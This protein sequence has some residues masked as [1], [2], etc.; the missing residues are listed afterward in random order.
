AIALLSVSGIARAEPAT[1][2]PPAQPVP[3]L[4]PRPMTIRAETQ[5][6]AVEPVPE[7]DPAEAQRRLAQLARERA[8]RLVELGDAVEAG[9]EGAASTARSRLRDLDGLVAATKAAN[10]SHA[11]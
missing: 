11:V 7:V 1:S 2:A 4:A 8:R 6:K 3:A 10:N 9:D 5:P